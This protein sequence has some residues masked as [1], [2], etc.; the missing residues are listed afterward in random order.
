MGITLRQRTTKAGTT[1]LYLDMYEGGRRRLEY[2]GLYLTGD[3]VA[4]RNALNLAEQIRAQRVLD[5]AANSYGLV[6]PSKQKLN[7]VEYCQQI[8]KS[9]PAENTRLVWRN[10]INHL[11]E[12]AG[13][14]VPIRLV[15]PSFMEGFRDH[16][17]KNVSVNSAGTYLA[18][19]KTAC[20]KATRDHILPD[21]AGE[22]VS[23]RKQKTRRRFL[24]LAEVAKLKKTPC[25]N[26]AVKDAFLFSCFAGLRYSDVKA[27]SWDK[28]KTRGK[29][30]LIEF[31]Q[32]KT[33]QVETLPLGVE[34]VAILKAQRDAKPAPA[35]KSEIPDNAVFQLPAQQT[36]DKALKKWARAAG[37]KKPISFH[38]G[39]HT[40]A[41]LGL[42]HGVDLYVM[43]KLLGHTRVDTTQIYAEVLDSSKQEAVAMLP[44]LGAGK[45]RPRGKRHS[46]DAGR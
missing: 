36:T 44:T 30:T 12:Y 22:G 27:L 2:L 26:P 3:K 20:H 32:V 14:T 24:E 21:Y 9:K 13:P 19:I 31:T 35:V 33:G 15:T 39:R 23:I 4:D 5:S 17:T 34:A 41:T 43:S 1:T 6:A 16:L 8:G 42:K 7:F 28:I 25:S 29:H 18:R 38:C 10:A 37:L 45:E 40:F 46:P 11:I